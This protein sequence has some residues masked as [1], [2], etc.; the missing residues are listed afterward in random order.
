MQNPSLRLTRPWR[1]SAAQGNRQTYRDIQNGFGQ[2]NQTLSYRDCCQFG[3]PPPNRPKPDFILG[4]P[5]G[6]SFSV[7]FWAFD[8]QGRKW[9]DKDDKVADGAG[10]EEENA[11]EA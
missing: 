6:Q 5:R 11:E 1:H 2:R 9:V 3:Q 8:D 10:E 7:T 4:R